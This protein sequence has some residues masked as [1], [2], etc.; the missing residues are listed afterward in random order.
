MKTFSHL[1]EKITS[2][3]TLFQAWDEFKKGKRKKIDVGFFERNLEDNIFQLHRE[4]V[5]KTYKHASY[6]G[7]YITDPK[8]RHIHK[9]EVKDRIVHH[10]L[11]K[12][13]N[14]IFEP[15]FIS[16][17]FSCREGFGTHKG[18]KKLVSYARRVSKNYTRDRWVLK[19]D[20]RK[21][22]DSVDHEVLL[23]IIE[24]KIEDPDLIWLMRQIV[25]S[26]QFPP[27]RW[28][29]ANGC[30]A[31]PCKAGI[32]IGNLTSQLFANVYLNRLDQ[33]VK[34]KLKAKHYV[35][36]A[37]DFIILHED[38]GF[39]QDSID[40]IKGF[41]E[42]ELKLELHKSKTFLR[43]LSWGID[44]VGYVALPFY[45]IVRTK[46]KKRLYRKIREKINL[47]KSNRLSNETLTQS[48]QSYLGILKHANTYNFEQELKNKIWF[49]FEDS[50]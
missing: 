43:K 34:H 8:V 35:R 46:T 49:W 33:F 17:S 38:L 9:A 6:T 27:P 22:F 20:I 30:K 1:Y 39:L 36:Y 3:D 4:L 44:F 14:P 12:V 2:L 26:Y 50:N 32:P 25:K 42:E 21:F 5:T 48:V 10:A 29:S 31:G 16:D 18:F 28:T 13:L 24:R 45:Q 11:F 37:D 23:E 47:Y 41:L 15:T 40:K 19:C 7:F